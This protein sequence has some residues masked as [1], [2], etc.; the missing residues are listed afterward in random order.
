MRTGVITQPIY[1]P[2]V[3][4]FDLM[5]RSDIFVL[6]DSVQFDKRSW[7]QRNRIKCPR[8]ELMLTVP[9]L[10]KGQFHQKIQD[11]RIDPGSNFVKDHIKAIQLNYAR[12]EYFYR[13]ADEVF[14]ILNKKHV[15]LADLNIDLI[16]WF[17][18]V[19][20]IQ[21]EIVRSS[22]L[23]VLGKKSELLVH[24]CKELGIERYLSSAG[25]MTYIN[26]NNLFDENGIQLNYQNYEPV[27]YRQLHGEFIPYLSMLD[28]L[29]N[30]GKESLNIVRAGRCPRIEV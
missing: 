17:K 16:L 27:P 18:D 24:I 4:Y 15:L 6:L 23:N 14:A 11:V 8:G 29:F 12:S 5:D 20:R 9:V 21:T 1:L 28:L 22:S 2:W 10:S 26:E 25:S 13:Y 3:G 7:Q 30:E 19:L